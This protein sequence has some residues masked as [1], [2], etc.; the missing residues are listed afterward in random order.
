MA[1]LEVWGRAG[2]HPRVLV[3][4]VLL[5]HQLSELQAGVTGAELL[6]LMLVRIPT[7]ELGKAVDAYSML[8]KLRLQSELSLVYENP[9]F[10]MCS[11]ACLSPLIKTTY[12][13][14]S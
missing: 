5:C 9:D 12:R 14:F 4:I 13:M 11:S 10:R 2:R 7:A 8:N 1:N 3:F 6:A